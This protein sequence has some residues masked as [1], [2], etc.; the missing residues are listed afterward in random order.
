MTDLEITKLCAE[1]MGL[2][3]STG[4]GLWQDGR[5]NGY[6]PLRYDVERCEL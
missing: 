5:T 4:V 1:A 6:D 3:F 2:P